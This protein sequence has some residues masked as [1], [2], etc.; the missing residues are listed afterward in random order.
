VKVLVID[1]CGEV[2]SVALGDGD[3]AVVNESLPARGSS[4]ALLPTVARLLEAKGWVLADLDGVGVVNGPGSF[5]GVRVGLAAAKGLCEAAG[6][7]LAAVSRLEM[8]AVAAGLEDGLAVLD[9]GRGEFYVR[10]VARES[11]V[12]EVL[13]GLDELREMAAGGRVVVAEE[14]LLDRLSGLQPEMIILE[15]ARALPLVLREFKVGSEDA[16]LVD[17]NYV[18]G[19]REIYGKVRDSVNGDGV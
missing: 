7:P 18:R 17:A 8:L 3:A 1:T 14:R 4:S 9:A 12:Q 5:T 15:A 6:L 19:E 16:A 13:C 10:V 11:A 2:G